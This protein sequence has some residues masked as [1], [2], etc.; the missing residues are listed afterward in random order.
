MRNSVSEFFCVLIVV[1]GVAT[2]GPN[3]GVSMSTELNISILKA[4]SLAS[5]NDA[6]EIRVH[7]SGSGC[8]Q[9]CSVFQQ[10]H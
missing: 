6:A 5:G 3:Q 4:R 8:C 10:A 1:A 2:V 9:G 7:I